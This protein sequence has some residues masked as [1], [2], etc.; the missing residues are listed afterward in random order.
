MLTL[1][2]SPAIAMDVMIHEE[3]SRQTTSRGFY[4]EQDNLTQ[5]DLNKWVAK[6]GAEI[7]GLLNRNDK[8]GYPEDPKNPAYYTRSEHWSKKQDYGVYLVDFKKNNGISA[9]TAIKSILE[10]EGR[11][12]CRIAQ[13]IVFLE[14]MR[15]L[16]GAGAFDE[17]SHQF[18]K[19]LS[20]DYCAQKGDTRMLHLCGSESLNPY[21]RLTSQ[22]N[23]SLHRCGIIGYFGY[24]PNI[25][26]Y[27]TL[28]F[29]GFLR[30]DHGLLC[31]DTNENLY[32]G[33]GSFYKDGGL[34]WDDVVKRFEEETLTL[35]VPEKIVVN[36][37][38][39]RDPKKRARYIAVMEKSHASYVQSHKESIDSLRL[40]FKKKF[41]DRQYDPNDSFFSF[42]IDLNKLKAFLSVSA[43]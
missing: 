5:E 19:E 13:R 34:C 20:Q 24:I 31:S 6:N 10:S 35:S 36:E 42:F 37:E 18:E 7:Y 2:M 21:R 29:H 25:K 26:E 8:I 41:K 4:F 22:E 14:C 23:G 40:T 43:E 33:F 9:S 32:V 3:S 15:R 11:F 17:C 1:G 16:M 12:D 38:S 30:G 39:I 27:A 28:H